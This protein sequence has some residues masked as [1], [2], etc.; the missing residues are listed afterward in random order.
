MSMFMGPEARE[1]SAYGLW[2]LA[3]I[4]LVV[5]FSVGVS[6]SDCDHAP[7]WLFWG[8]GLVGIL[9]VLGVVLHRWE[10]PVVAIALAAVLL[11]VL[12]IAFVLMLGTGFAEHCSA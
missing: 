8:W 5:C 9:G 2:A 3:T 11:L 7:G 12:G 1:G 4:L 6:W 10:R